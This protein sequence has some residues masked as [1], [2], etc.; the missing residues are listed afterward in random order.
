MSTT[1]SLSTFI[2]GNS[3]FRQGDFLTVFPASEC[4]SDTAL[5]NAILSVARILSLSIKGNKG[6]AKQMEFE[7]GRHVL[8][9]YGFGRYIL[10]T[11]QDD[12]TYSDGDNQGAI[13][14]DLLARC[15]D[16]DLDDIEE[17]LHADARML[18]SGS[19]EFSAEGTVLMRLFGADG[20][21]DL[22][23]SSNL[24]GIRLALAEEDA[25]SDL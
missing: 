14:Q 16:Y 4:H 24:Y 5:R 13:T 22:A 3:R 25:V 11:Y 1:A 21:C 12:F 15:D 18:L 10:G 2:E 8:G 19:S 17:N 7:I 6:E 23:Y 9:G 20:A